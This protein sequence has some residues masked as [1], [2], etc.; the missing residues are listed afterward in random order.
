M[1]MNMNNRAQRRTA[2]LIETNTLLPSYR[3]R[4]LYIGCIVRSYLT[5]RT[6]LR[7]TNPWYPAWMTV[8][9]RSC[10]IN[11]TSILAR[12][13]RYL[14]WILIAAKSSSVSRSSNLCDT[15]HDVRGLQSLQLTAS[16]I[17]PI[18]ILTIDR[19]RTYSSTLSI[20]Q[21]YTNITYFTCST[22]FITT[23][24]C[25]PINLQTISN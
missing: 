21:N 22:D 25:Y 1:N 18:S 14:V 4:P 24:I 13:C 11:C 10:R 16:T 5:R 2:S 7:A 3:Q 20:Y 15:I 23:A 17:R 19:Y 6:D 12:Y 9:A 8:A